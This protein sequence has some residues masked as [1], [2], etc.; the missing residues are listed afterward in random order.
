MNFK[1][2]LDLNV[3]AK[4]IE[5]EENTEKNLSDLVFGKYFLN[6]PH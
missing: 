2:I 1:R 3:R 6:L 5:L 4:A